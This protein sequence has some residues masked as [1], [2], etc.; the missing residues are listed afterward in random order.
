MCVNWARHFNAPF[1]RSGA[2]SSRLG[3]YEFREPQKGA[4]DQAA[5]LVETVAEIA[6]LLEIVVRKGTG[7]ASLERV[8]KCKR[9]ADTFILV[10][11]GE[12]YESAGGGGEPLREAMKWSQIYDR[13]EEVA[14]CLE[15][16]ANVIAGV[17]LKK[18]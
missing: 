4:A 18:V 16:T 12:V 3:L 9:E 10:G 17:I 14:S 1:K 15:H 6:P 7:A 8:R 11:L 2:V 13:L 5:C